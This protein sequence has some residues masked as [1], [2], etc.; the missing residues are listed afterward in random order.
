MVTS[1]ALG[2]GEGDT[3]WVKLEGVMMSVCQ[4]GSADKAWA[5]VV[6]VNVADTSDAA[7]LVETLHVVAVVALGS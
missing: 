6:E 2:N 1:N 4:E 5:D 7:E 3:L